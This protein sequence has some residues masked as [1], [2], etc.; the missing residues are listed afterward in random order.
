MY[1]TA[2]SEN[3]TDEV[4]DRSYVK[5]TAYT[6]HFALGHLFQ[7]CVTLKLELHALADWREGNK[8][9][10]K[11]LIID[12][13]TDLAE[14]HRV[15]GVWVWRGEDMRLMDS[16]LHVLAT[17]LCVYFTQRRTLSKKLRTKQGMATM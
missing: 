5:Y 16:R 8:F 10:Q 11:F 3:G 7:N 17:V 13:F 1:R 14:I 2:Y 6:F 12:L 4:I 9:V 15:L